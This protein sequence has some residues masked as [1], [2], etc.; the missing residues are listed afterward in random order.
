[1]KKLVL[2]ISIFC[3]LNSFSQTQNPDLFQTWYLKYVL[4]NDMMPVFTVSQI[5]TAIPPTITF[6]NTTNP[7]LLPFTGTGSCNSFNGAFTY[8]ANSP[9]PMQIDSYYSTLLICNTTTQSNLESAYSCLLHSQLVYSITPQG[10]GLLLTLGNTFMGEA[11]YQNFP[12]K[13]TEFIKEHIELYPNPSDTVLNLI[14]NQLSISRIQIINAFGI[15]V[16]TL[17]NGFETIDVSDLSSGIYFL[18][19]ETEHGTLIEKFC[20]R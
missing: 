17:N 2:L 13:Y 8:D 12:L 20:K 6:T 19:L 11:I 7:N 3:G 16:K 1:M 15:T 10:S 4:C 9:F 18:K 5:T 14:Y